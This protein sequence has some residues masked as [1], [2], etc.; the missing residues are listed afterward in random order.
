MSGRGNRAFASDEEYQVI[1]PTLPTGR[2]VLNTV[3]LHAD[4]RARPYRVEDFRDALAQLML[5]PEVIAL[6]AYRMSHV[7]A[8]TF[9]SAEAVTKILSAGDLKVKDRR[10]LVIDPANQDV[11]VKLHWLLHNVPDEDVRVAFASYGKVSEVSKERWRVQGVASKGSTTRLVSLKMNPG[12]K[13]EDLPHEVRVGGELALVVVPGRAPLCLRCHGTGHIRRECKVPRCGA[14]RRYGH[15]ESSCV[16]TY[17]SAAVPVNTDIS[18]ELVMDEAD[19]EDAAAEAGDSVEKAPAVPPTE[20]S[21]SIEEPSS[22]LALVVVPGRAP[23]CLRCRNTGHIRR[24]C[25][26]PRCAL[27]QRY[28][29][30]EE[31][32]VKTYASVTQKAAR[33]LDVND[34]LQDE[35]EVEEAS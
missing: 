23:L 4:V 14:C 21:T 30:G 8:V 12:V 19:A 18:S 24:D 15:E 6:G 29:H 35:A 10:C 31:Q 17:A 25:C 11:R 32:C 22:E 5:L 34:L 1:L 13:L 28:G 33:V 3:F 2:V 16:R 20:I 27:C 7:W 9:A 26:V